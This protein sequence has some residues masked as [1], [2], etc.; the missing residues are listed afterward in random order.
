MKVMT[1]R[2][3]PQERHELTTPIGSPD[4]V[5]HGQPRSQGCLVIVAAAALAA[6]TATYAALGATSNS[7]DQTDD[8]KSVATRVDN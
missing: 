4:K 1:E 2:L 3:T 6:S 5:T 7:E 8:H